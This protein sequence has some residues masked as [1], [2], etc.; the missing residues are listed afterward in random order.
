[1]IHVK[2][3]SRLLSFFI[4]SLLVLTANSLQAQEQFTFKDVLQFEDIKSP[5]LS[6]N[7]EWVAYG[8][9]PEIGDGEVI[10]KSVNGSSEYVIERGKNPQDIKEWSMGRSNCASTLY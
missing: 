10:I 2:R 5:V 4:I 9:W 8:V 3:S 1:M 7:G 6:A